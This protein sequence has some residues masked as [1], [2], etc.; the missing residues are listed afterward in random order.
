M[1]NINNMPL[2]FSPLESFEPVIHTFVF[3]PKQLI[4]LTSPDL[5]LIGITLI[6]FAMIFNNV[7]NK[8]KFFDNDEDIELE[9]NFFASL[10]WFSDEFDKQI[11]SKGRHY[12]FLVILTGLLILLLNEIGSTSGAFLVTSFITST[13]TFSITINC[14]VVIEGVRSHGLSFFKRF[15]P[16][17][18]AVGLTQLVTLI[19][20]FSYVLRV[21]SLAIRLTA[22]RRAG[23][24]LLSICLSAFASVASNEIS[25]FAFAIRATL[26]TLLI[27]LESAVA[28]IQSYVFALLTS[29]YLNEAIALH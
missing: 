17:N 24:I 12:Y 7:I 22:N 16:K 13:L 10:L 18:L 15:I 20:V 6:T 14:I 19:E 8:I 1:I 11:D 27:L 5:V 3:T 23:H 4:I 21:F 2:F 28:I 29:I 9:K 25:F 26:V